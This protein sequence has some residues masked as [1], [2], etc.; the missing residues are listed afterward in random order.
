[1]LKHSGLESE[2]AIHR[3]CRFKRAPTRFIIISLPFK[4]ALIHIVNGVR[5]HFCSLSFTDSLSLD[6]SAHRKLQN[7][8]ILQ[9]QTTCSFNKQSTKNDTKNKEKTFI[10]IKRHKKGDDDHFKP[11]VIT[12]SPQS[13]RRLQNRKRNKNIISF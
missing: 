7:R 8:V 13:I 1:M 2:S 9:L 10:K 5:I 6:I 4:L 3:H 11:F 12:L